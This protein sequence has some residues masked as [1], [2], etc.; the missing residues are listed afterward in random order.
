[1]KNNVRARLPYR[2]QKQE[3]EQLRK[4]TAIGISGFESFSDVQVRQSQMFRRFDRV[5][6]DTSAFD[7]LRHCGPE[8]CAYARCSA[9]CH[10]GTR[11]LR[12]KEI[13]S[14]YERFKKYPGPLHVVHVVHPLWQ[15]PVG[16]LH[17]INIEAARQWN[18]RH[19]RRLQGPVIA[20]GIFE[21][22]LNRELDGSLHW[23]GQIHEVV[24]G[25]SEKELDE[26]F[27]LEPRYRQPHSAPVQIKP[28]SNL[29]YQLGYCLKRYVEER[30]AYRSPSNGR[31]NRRELPLLVQHQ[32]EHDLWLAGLPGR[33]RIITH[34]F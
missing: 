26:T 29:G 28:I 14:S 22:S 8:Y 32:V 11:Q 7:E 21:V 13:L 5:G 16:G 19:L 23:A 1:M 18:Y 6:I 9:G 30:R 27:A 25:S 15:R 34:G 24:G 20:K 33:A 2:I 10:F 17:E 12:L 4:M 3:R 31:K